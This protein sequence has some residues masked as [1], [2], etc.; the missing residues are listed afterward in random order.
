MQSTVRL[1]A[2]A[3]L[4]ALAAAATAVAEP[5]GLPAPSTD[6]PIVQSSPG[7]PVWVALQH[8]P[9]LETP[10]SMLLL[11]DG[12]VLLHSDLTDQWA[13]LTPAPHGS[14]LHGTW[15]RRAP[16]PG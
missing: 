3:V 11:S 8:Q 13:A 2:V 1:A 15:R 7:P 10:G 16:L 9:P 6:P 12:R 5:T 4:V 14:Y